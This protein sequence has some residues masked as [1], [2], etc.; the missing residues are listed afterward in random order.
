VTGRRERRKKQ[1]RENREEGA[2]KEMEN[3]RR[4]KTLNKEVEMWDYSRITKFIL[5]KTELD[6][7]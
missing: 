7:S 5:G 4:E 2:T 3:K 6:L 1:K